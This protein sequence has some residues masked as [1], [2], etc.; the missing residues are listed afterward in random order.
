LAYL[1][2]LQQGRRSA[3]NICFFHF[4]M[5]RLAAEFNASS[6]PSSAKVA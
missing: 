4:S 3:G 5:R 1:V 6:K 2:A